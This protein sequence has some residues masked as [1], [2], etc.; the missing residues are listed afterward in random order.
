MRQKLNFHDVDDI[1][2]YGIGF[3]IDD[4]NDGEALLK[5]TQDQN[6]KKHDYIPNRTK[7]V[8]TEDSIVK[9]PSKSKKVTLLF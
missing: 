7:K 5:F 1:A 3:G 8:R 4:D 6:S 2:E 9:K